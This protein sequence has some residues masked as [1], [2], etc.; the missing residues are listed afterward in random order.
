MGISSRQVIALSAGLLAFAG[1]GVATAST[2]NAQLSCPASDQHPIVSTMARARSTL[3]PRGARRVL[4]CRYRGLGPRSSQ[5][6]AQ[7]LVSQLATVRSLASTLDRI[8]NPRGTYSCPGDPGKTI[9]AFFE[10]RSNAVN[11][12]TVDLGD[13]P[14]SPTGTCTASPE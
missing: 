8:P 1:T 7:H 2:A 10:Y 14:A 13:A 4:L 3:V 12:V 9:I 11:P 6:S 5:L